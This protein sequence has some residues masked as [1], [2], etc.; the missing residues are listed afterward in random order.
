MMELQPALSCL[1][2]PTRLWRREEVLTSPSPVP[3]AP[4]VYAWY[5][6]ELPGIDLS[7]CHQR[8]GH[9]LLY[10]GISPKTPPSNGA[11]PSSE[12]LRKRLRTHYSGNAEG[13]TLRLTLGCLLSVVLDIQLRRVGRG[14]RQTF[15]NPGEQRLDEW[16]DR[17]AMVAWMECEK[18][19][20]IEGQILSSGTPLPLNLSGYSRRDLNSSVSAARRVAKQGAVALPIV[21]DN[22]GPRRM[23]PIRAIA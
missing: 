5:F 19:W 8:D 10:V 20:M 23:V 4:G 7:G 18:P 9:S 1:F 16:M 14:L 17:H 2:T 13:S 12:N 11:K 15:T 21:A 22:G 6:D 3:K